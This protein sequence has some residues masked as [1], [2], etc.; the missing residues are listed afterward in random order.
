MAG[1]RVP[2][3]REVLQGGRRSSEE[4]PVRPVLLSLPLLLALL[5][6][7][8]NLVTHEEA[9]TPETWVWVDA[10]G[11]THLTVKLPRAG[12]IHLKAT[13][14]A[15][16]VIQTVSGE[17]APVV[18]MRL[19]EGRREIAGFGPGRYRFLSRAKG[20]AIVVKEIDVGDR[21]APRVL[22]L[23]GGAAS[24]LKVRVVDADDNPVRGVAIK[25]VTEGGFPFPT[26]QRTDANGEVV[27][28]RLI[29]GRI[30]VVATKDGI[31][32]EGLLD[33]E[34]G[35]EHSITVRR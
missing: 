5:L 32:G 28:K 4:F 26:G 23:T 11:V 3:E 17:P 24:T 13:P 34:P 9:E 2:R 16:V 10:H 12:T 33:I 6:L 14:G 18:T 19:E 15:R 21:D 27:L 29:L 25:L 31:H 35:K 1:V 8:A 20:E 30:R 22:D 7:A